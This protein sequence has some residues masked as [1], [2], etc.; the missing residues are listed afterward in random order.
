MM[1]IIIFSVISVFIIAIFQFV[2]FKTRKRK[3][4]CVCA[5]ENPETACGDKATG[6]CQYNVR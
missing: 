4:T 6:C 1:K 3:H 2:I 5:A